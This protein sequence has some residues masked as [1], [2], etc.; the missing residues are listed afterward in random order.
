MMPSSHILSCGGK[1]SVHSTKDFFELIDSDFY[2]LKEPLELNPQVLPIVKF[3][4]FNRYLNGDIHVETY[5]VREDTGGGNELKTEKLIL[6]AE[7]I[8]AINQLVSAVPC[9]RIAS[10]CHTKADL[11]GESGHNAESSMPVVSSQIMDV[12]EGS[13]KATVRVSDRLHSRVRLY[14][15]EPVLELVREWEFVEC[16]LLEIRILPLENRKFQSVYSICIGGRLGSLSES[17]CFP[18][19]AIKSR[20]QLISHLS[21]FEREGIGSDLFEHAG[22]GFS[23]DDIPPAVFVISSDGGK[24]VL[25]KESFP[26]RIESFGVVFRSIK[27]APAVFE[28]L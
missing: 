25:L 1:A 16:A 24:A 26:L 8:T 7:K 23:S 3:D 11:P 10:S 12:F 5:L 13:V 6:T 14:R 20:T 2:R 28:P 17:Y 4:L 9:G 19:E 21:E 22:S 15:R 18:D 27:P